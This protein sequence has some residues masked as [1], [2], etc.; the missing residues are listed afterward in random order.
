MAVIKLDGGYNSLPISYKRGNPIPLDKSSV[1]YDYDLMMEYAATNGTAY[2]GQILSLVNA[3]DNSAK[4]YII[5]NQS[6]DLEEIGTGALI[7]SIGDRLGDVET[8]ISDIQLILNSVGAPADEDS[9]ATGLFAEIAKK[10]NAEDVYTKQE[11][12][13]K[14]EAEVAKAPH[15]KRKEVASIDEIDV[16]APDADEYVYMVPSGLSNEDNKYYEYLVM[17]IEIAD[18]EGVVTKVKKVE[19]IGSWEVNL[20]DYAKLTDLTTESNRAKD[21]EDALGE[22]LSALERKDETN[23]SRFE[24]IDK[25]IEDLNNNKVDKS[26][27]N[28]ENED[29]TTSKVEGTLLTPEEK[30]KLSALVIDEN[31]SVGV[32]GY[33]NVSKVQGLEEWMKDEAHKHLASLDEDNL[34]AD[35]VNKINFITTVDTTS[36]TV[37][38]GNLSLNDISINKVSGLQNVVTKVETLEDAIN[39]EETGLNALHGRLSIIEGTY[40]TQDTFNTAVGNLNDLLTNKAKDLSDRINLLDQRMSWQDLEN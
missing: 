22:R 7:S 12:I 25:D 37:S 17:E 29:G 38:N 13:S 23:D 14:I 9:E 2:V 15:L 21:A 24:N 27:Y 39:A 35:T 18:D 20:N 19:R 36:F 31:G 33:V 3:E 5:L 4:A 1:W 26:W 8:Q 40:V 32:S 28:V 10:A 30:K 6:G 11:T 16:D 34:S